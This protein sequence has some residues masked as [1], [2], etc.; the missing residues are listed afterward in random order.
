MMEAMRVKFR[1]RNGKNV[2]RRSKVM[3]ATEVSNVF[4][5]ACHVTAFYKAGD[6]RGS[7]KASQG[8]LCQPPR[9]TNLNPG[10]EI[11][12]VIEGI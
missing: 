8:C 10:A 11:Y 2:P 6:P 7:V 9:A 12:G 1:E 5:R 3:L 4:S